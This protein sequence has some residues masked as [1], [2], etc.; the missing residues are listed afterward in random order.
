MTTAEAQRWKEYNSYEA[1][2]HKNLTKEAL[3]AEINNITHKIASAR[4]A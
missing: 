4:E 1:K 2:D 3:K